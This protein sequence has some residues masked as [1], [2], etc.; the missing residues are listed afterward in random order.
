M[1]PE[2]TPRRS[3]TE[4]AQKIVAIDGCVL[5]CAKKTLARHDIA[6]S[7][8]VELWRLGVRKRLHEDFS[9]DEAAAA[10]AFC[11]EVTA[12]VSAEVSAEAAAEPALAAPVA[13]A[14]SA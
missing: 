10:L 5:A 12:E 4:S 9:A 6:A 7:R 11:R 13:A 8:H 3:S 14:R 1:H 2:S